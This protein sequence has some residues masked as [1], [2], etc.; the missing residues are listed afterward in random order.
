MCVTVHLYCIV[1]CRQQV[2]RFADCAFR[3]G[4]CSHTSFEGSLHIASGEAHPCSEGL[5]NALMCLFFGDSCAVQVVTLVGLYGKE[6][7]TRGGRS[8]PR[9]R[10]P[11]CC[12][13][14]L[15]LLH[16]LITEKKSL[17]E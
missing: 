7:V 2:V 13:T 6:R 5:C 14:V 10:S 9:P 15:Q 3:C 8:R 11:C 16:L 1:N 17:C 12:G 4:S